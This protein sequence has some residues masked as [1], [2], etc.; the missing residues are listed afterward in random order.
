MFYVTYECL[1]YN[2]IYTLR[3]A[4]RARDA[5]AGEGDGR[6]TRAR[7]G[8]RIK[9]RTVPPEGTSV[10][11]RR[12]LG[13]GE[14]AA[15]G[16]SGTEPEGGARAD[17]GREEKVLALPPQYILLYGGLA[18]VLAELV[19][20]PLETVRRQLQM[21]TARYGGAGRG[22][23]WLRARHARLVSGSSAAARAGRAAARARRMALFLVRNGG[24]PRRLYLGAAPSALQIL[25]SAALSFFLFQQMKLLLGVPP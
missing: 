25:P 22:S 12:R 14:R 15:A 19:V 10:G 4:E 2:H 17:A 21:Q 20:Y 18:G 13:G 1:S 9:D 24:G 7:A 6:A 23:A 3:K 11:R 8:A 5:G 16:R